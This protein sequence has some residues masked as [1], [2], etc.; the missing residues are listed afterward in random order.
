[1][2]IHLN[3]K[4]LYINGCSWCDGD[5][6]DNRR[7]ERFSYK[8]SKDLNLKEIN[9]SKSA[10][11][12]EEII[13]KTL[14]WI[15]KNKRKLKDTFFIVGFTANTRSKFE[16]DYFDI[17]L[18]ENYLKSLNLEYRL[19]FSFGISHKKLFNIR[20]ELNKNVFTKLTFADF[21]IKNGIKKSLNDGFCENG[22]PNKI[23]HEKFADYLKESIIETE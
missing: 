13:L 3:K 18:F 14:R 17:V 15:S 19:F 6:L 23:S 4:N 12:N 16:W 20:K 9:Q 11:S 8:L 5:E 10:I 21:I 2:E 22:H 1:M 7:K